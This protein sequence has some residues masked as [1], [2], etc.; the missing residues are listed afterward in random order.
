MSKEIW[1]K[2]YYNNEKLHYSVSD[3]GQI[4]NDKTGNI[5]AQSSDDNNY[6]FIT[7]EL[8]DGT[9][10]MFRVHRLV[11]SMFM[12][13]RCS[14]EIEVNH[15]D[16]NTS[17]NNIEN[18]EWCTHAENM[19]HANANNLIKRNTG[20]DHPGCKYSDKFIDD[21][22]SLMRQGLNNREICDRLNIKSNHKLIALF[23]SIRKG[24][25]RL[26]STKNFD[27]IPSHSSKKKWDEKFVKDICKL[28][29]KGYSTLE[30]ASR[31][32][33]T[34]KSSTEVK[35]LIRD[36]KKGKRF[37]SIGITYDLYN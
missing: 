14:D 16:G 30:V 21:V 11:A 26:K 37:K 4:R 29:S 23:T 27:D 18:L 5:L 12:P 31:L 13:V 22:V 19:K 35:A 7:L 25:G 9:R 15:K 34:G 28:L 17:N 32:D 36:I 6:K 1:T 3:C 10:K 2:I 24:R 33:L 20:D 8:N